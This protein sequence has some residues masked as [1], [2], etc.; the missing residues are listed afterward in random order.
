MPDDLVRDPVEDVKDKEG[1]WKGC[2]GDCVN[3]FGPVHKL[4]LHHVNVF[5]YRWW[6][7]RDR[8]GI[9]HRIPI[10]H[11]Q[12]L[13]HAIAREVETSISHVIILVK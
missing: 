11:L 13:S 4:F 12:T 6:R 8:D 9:F 7:G 5:L 1:Q 2:S 3:P 10:L